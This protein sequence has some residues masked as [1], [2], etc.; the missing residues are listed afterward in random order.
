MEIFLTVDLGTTS[1]KLI[2]WSEKGERKFRRIP[3]R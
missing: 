2:W 3:F 1:V